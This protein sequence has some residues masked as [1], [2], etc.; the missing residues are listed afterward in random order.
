MRWAV[1]EAVGRRGGG[2]AAWARERRRSVHNARL[3]PCPAASAPQNDAGCTG[4]RAPGHA[5][6]APTHAGWRHAARRWAE[7]CGFARGG[8]KR[9]Q[10]NQLPLLTSLTH[11]FHVVSRPHRSPRRSTL[12]SPRHHPPPRPTRPHM[13]GRGGAGRSRTLA[14]LVGAGALLPGPNVLSCSV[15][16]RDYYAGEWSCLCVGGGR[17]RAWG[18]APGRG[19]A[20]RA[21]SR[22]PPFVRRPRRHAARRTLSPPPDDACDSTR[23]LYGANA[24]PAADARA[25]GGPIPADR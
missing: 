4:H 15:A 8:K 11:Q 9:C 6:L 5:G 2:R 13:A 10:Q 21:E 7:S 1:L 25:G 24:V 22:L 20:A 19:A 14:P 16:G 23:S 3:S 17:A 18:W 12:N